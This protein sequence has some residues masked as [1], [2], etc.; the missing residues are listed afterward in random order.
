MNIMVPTTRIRAN[1]GRKGTR[2]EQ[3]YVECQPGDPAVRRPTSP[4]PDGHRE[5]RGFP[6]VSG[7]DGKAE[8]VYPAGPEDYDD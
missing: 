3:M 2:F 8:T 6:L 1:V 7:W 4:I 5:W